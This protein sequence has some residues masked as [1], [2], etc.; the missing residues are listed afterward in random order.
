MQKLAG[1]INEQEKESPEEAA[2]D[3]DLIAT[4]N[5]IAGALGKQL[6]AKKGQATGGKEKLDEAVVTSV[7][8][9]VMSGNAIVGLVSK[10]S[11]N[12][13]KKL[14]WKKGEDIAEKIQ[15]WAHDNEKAFQAPIKRVLGFFIKDP[16]KLELTVKAIY[17][18]VVLT[19]AG[20]AGAG[21]IQKLSKADW[22][23]GSFKALK[24]IAKADEVIANAYPIVKAIGG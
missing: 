13:F 22:F 8:A 11:K 5:T 19:M 3:K 24:T 17:A 18:L 7:I 20:S 12:L 4:A 16:A 2:F 6:K 21:A 9:A 23:I 15:H 10:L 14:G 1:I